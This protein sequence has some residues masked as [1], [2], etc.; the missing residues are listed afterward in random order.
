MEE[1]KIYIPLED[2]ELIERFA[3]LD[4]LNIPIEKLRE[5]DARAEENFEILIAMMTGFTMTEMAR[6]MHVQGVAPFTEND[7]K[8]YRYHLEEAAQEYLV[9]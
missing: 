5:R 2:G 7:A 1:D 6:E 8:R 9:G 3:A 4:R